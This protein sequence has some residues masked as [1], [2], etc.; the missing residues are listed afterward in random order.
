M[1]EPTGRKRLATFAAWLLR[2]YDSECDRLDPNRTC[3]ADW[4]HTVG[5]REAARNMLRLV[6]RRDL[7]DLAELL[8]AIE[9]RQRTQERAIANEPRVMA[10]DKIRGKR[11]AYRRI[12]G[13]V[14]RRLK[15]AATR[16]VY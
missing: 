9:D 8:I 6:V 14:R 2:W 10:R 7:R 11:D 13:V 12:A 16:R 5:W 3:V 15:A 1:N 4:M